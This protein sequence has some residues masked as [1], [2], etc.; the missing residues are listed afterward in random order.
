M[1]DVKLQH[2]ILRVLAQRPAN[3]VEIAGVLREWTPFV[4]D[5]LRAM[6]RSQLVAEIL[7]PDQ[8]L[9][10]LTDRGWRS[11]MP[12]LN[13]QLRVIAGDGLP[14]KITSEVDQ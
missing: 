4:R 2:R 5:E 1:A 10:R 8:I 12:I 14:D 6:R 13:P 7:K 9:W 3:V 11:V